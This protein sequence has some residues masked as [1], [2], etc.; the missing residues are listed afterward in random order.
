MYHLGL[1]NF[2]GSQMVSNCAPKSTEKVTEKVNFV[3]FW[4][5]MQYYSF[6]CDI[7]QLFSF[8]VYIYYFRFDSSFYTTL[9]K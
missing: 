1:Q 3:L 6:T 5:N 9:Q 7:L 2:H 8:Y 4:N